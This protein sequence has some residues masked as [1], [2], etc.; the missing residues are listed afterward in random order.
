MPLPD[1]I[2]Y[3]DLYEVAP[4]SAVDRSLVRPLNEWMQALTELEDEVASL[5]DITHTATTDPT[6]NDDVSAGFLVGA[7]WINTAT[8]EFFTCIDN[9]AGAAVWVGSIAATAPGYIPDN[10]YS[11]VPFTD[12]RSATLLN[13][14][15]LYPFRIHR[16][17]TIQSLHARMNSGGTASSAKVGIWA[18]SPISNKPLGAP[19]VV[20]NIGMATTTS[21]ANI[22][23]TIT[24][25]EFLPG[26]YWMGSKHTHGGISASMYS[27]PQAGNWMLSTMGWHASGLDVVSAAYSDAY[28]NDMPTIN[29]GATFTAV[30]DDGVPVFQFRA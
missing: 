4:T 29:E 15:L 7:L 10:Y 25:A 12:A 16:T 19:L 21:N 18:N 20:D 26:W 11:T 5:Q 9:T 6:V 8:R 14:V 3:A 2:A 13:S 23:A 30:I 28:A 24:P 22:T 17:V 1:K 27:L